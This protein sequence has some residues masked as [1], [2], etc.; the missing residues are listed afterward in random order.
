MSL[1]IR[2][3]RKA[4][5]GVVALSG[6]DIDITLDE[7]L[8]IVGPN[9]SGKTTLFNVVTGTMSP[10]AGSVT[11][12]GA[13]ITGKPAFQI[14]RLGIVRSF[15]QA[16]T[17]TG[18]TVAENIQIAWDHGSR[19]RLAGSA[20][21]SPEELFDF[22]GL[23]D[24]RSTISG[25]LS[26]G[27]L[28]RLGIAICLATHPKLLLMDEPAAGLNDTETD[29]LAQMI[30]QFPSMGVG[31]CIIDHNMNIISALCHRLAVLDFGTKIAEGAPSAVLRDPKVLEV[32][33]GADL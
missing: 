5:G 18:L 11:W 22:V 17:F 14:A 6:V 2:A 26:F 13:D 25:V 23:G 8:G 1:Q 33:L 7:I 32:Y 28:R 20:W 3:L 19:E 16:M 31:V 10:T 4:F 30:R 27:N 9:G 29:Q 24:A 12:N 21:T 15:Q